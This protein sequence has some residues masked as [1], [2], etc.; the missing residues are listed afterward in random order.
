MVT[1]ENG[2]SSEPVVEMFTATNVEP[3]IEVSGAATGSVG[4]AY[5]LTLGTV[6][7]PGADNVSQISVDWGDD[8]P[9]EV[10]AGIGDVEHSYI[11][12]GTYTI[13][14]G[15]LDEDGA[16]P[17]AATTSVT[18]TEQPALGA[19]T[20]TPDVVSITDGEVSLEVP[21]VGTV[22][23]ATV[24]WGDGTVP[25]PAT[26]GAG[27]ITADYDYTTTGVFPVTVTAEN[28][29]GDVDTEVFEFVVVFDPNGSSV[30]GNPRQQSPAGAYTAN[31]ILEGEVKAG[32]NVKYKK[33]SSEPKGKTKFEF[34]DAGLKLT[35]EGFD[36]LILS[37]ARAE[38]QGYGEL[39]NQDGLYGFHVIAIDGD[40]DP[41]DA[42][43][44][45]E[46]GIRIWDLDTGDDIYNT[47]AA[48]QG[49]TLP[50][51]KGKIKIKIKDPS[52]I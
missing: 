30:K 29:A 16:F 12:I 10:F 43:P 9:L 7:D 27:T 52:P 23:S 31:A 28:V 41:N 24:D 8:S 50:L 4:V 5:I 22:D 18:I 11:G 34:K 14:V 17:E 13:T 39:K 40:L 26:V 44:I 37:G 15:L 20:V 35:E 38:Y 21:F 3:T 2:L 46:F 36:W 6:I 32:V 42:F 25:V 19:I 48:G 1:D 51:S 45:D 47:A 49:L 33:N